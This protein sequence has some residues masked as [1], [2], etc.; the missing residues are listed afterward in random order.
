MNTYKQS[1]IVG[2]AFLCFQ[3]DILAQE[4]KADQVRLK[5]NLDVSLQ[6]YQTC[7]MQSAELHLT[8]PG[9]SPK[10]IADAAHDACEASYDSASEAATLYHTSMAPRTAKLDAI[11]TAME[12]MKKFKGTMRDT[13]VKLV[14]QKRG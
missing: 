13:V 6:A 14:K 2:A 8:D 5:E 10:V 9:K 3:S 4:S 12:Q 1:M 11:V 7:L